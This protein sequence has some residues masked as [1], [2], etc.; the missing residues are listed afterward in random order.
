MVVV[1]V[2]VALQDGLSIAVA[3]ATGTMM[4]GGVV[5]VMESFRR[6]E[7]LRL[8]RPKDYPIILRPHRRGPNENKNDNNNND[9]NNSGYRQLI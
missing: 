3:S 5:L 2:V 9:N 1:V 7:P 8:L 6:L 4:A